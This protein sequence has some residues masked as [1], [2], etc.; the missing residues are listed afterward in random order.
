[1]KKIAI[2]V[3]LLLVCGTNV[4]FAGSTPK[5]KPT[6][7]GMSMNMAMPTPPPIS[8]TAAMMGGTIFDAAIPSNVLSIPLQDAS[9]KTFT[10]GSLKGRAVVLTDFFTSCDMI[11]PMTTANMRTIGD[12]ISAAGQS[13]KIAVL[14]LSV[15]P[16]R[17]TVSRINAYQK[18]FGTSNWTIA[19]GTASDLKKLW[20]WFG[21]YAQQVPNTDGDADDW[22]TGKK[23]T[24]D[25]IHEDIVTLIGPNSHYRWIDLG[26]PQVSNP[27]ILPAKLKAFLSELG[28][29]N[30]V[31][32]Q[33]PSWSTA[34]VYDAMQQIF[35]LPIGP[36]MKM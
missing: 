26:N 7:D 13:K 6:P 30:L 5:P 9:G 10:L 28:L 32:P 22:Q 18:L 12:T 14:E 2:A 36:K 31:K 3:L 11:C 33:Q 27:T 20:A 24:Y 8:G 23:L 16:K 1:M 21:V 4:A 35:G 29:S 15:D 34:V 25:V 17:D 19:T